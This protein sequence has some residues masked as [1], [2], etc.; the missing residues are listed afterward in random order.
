MSAVRVCVRG[1]LCV[2]ECVH[3]CVC[4]WVCMC[5]VWPD[6][7]CER[8]WEGVWQSVTDWGRMRESMWQCGRK[9]LQRV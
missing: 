3:V 5:L 7:K 8:V 4:V 1:C 9:V 2:G 6:G